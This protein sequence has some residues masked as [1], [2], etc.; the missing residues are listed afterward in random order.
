[1]KKNKPIFQQSP[2]RRQKFISNNP[3]IFRSVTYIPP[4]FRDG[5]KSSGMRG[6]IPSP[7]MMKNAAGTNQKKTPPM[8][9]KVRTHLRM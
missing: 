6:E 2:H 3:Y 8:R 5:C 9:K 1:M 4:R 7:N